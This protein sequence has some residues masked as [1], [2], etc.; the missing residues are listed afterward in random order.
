M[1]DALTVVG[2]GDSIGYGIGD[3]GVNWS[4]PAWVGRF[5]HNVGADRVLHLATPGQRATDVLSVQVPAALAANPTVVLMSVGGNDLLRGDFNP[6]AILRCTEKAIARLVGVGATVI[7]LGLPQACLHD[8]LPT[9]VRKTISER[10]LLVNKALASAV[11]QHSRP[12]QGGRAH[13]IDLWTDP[14]SSQAGLWHIDRMHPSPQGHEYLAQLAAKVS[15]FHQC[16]VS[17]P[18][19]LEGRST[20][21]LEWLVRNGVPWLLRRSI[22]LIPQ[23]ILTMVFHRRR[24]TELTAQ[25]DEALTARFPTLHQGIAESPPSTI[26][27]CPVMNDDASLAK[28]SAA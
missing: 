9:V 6:V 4:G 5:A 1:R 12:R 20:G 14:R 27:S 25:L 10:A 2:L 17:L 24:V 22:D 11:R 28:N 18:V 21:K 23:A 13:F 26:N 16:Q 7:V 8:F 19:R 3:C 15:R